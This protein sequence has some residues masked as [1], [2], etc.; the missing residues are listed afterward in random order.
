MWYVI[1]TTTGQE[2]KTRLLI[3]QL[4]DKELYNRISIP[5]KYKIQKKD[6]QQHKVKYKLMPSY[7]FFETDRI[8]DFAAELKRVPG[9]NMVLQDDET[10]HPLHE[11]EV[12]LLSKLIGDEDIVEVSKGVIEGDQVFVTEGPLVGMEGMIKKINR[13]KRYAII[14]MEMFDRITEIKIGLEIVEKK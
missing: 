5:W 14:E 1:W 2:E 9:F 8:D 11:R 13:H 6:G 7:I 12:K 3:E 10:Y 4:I